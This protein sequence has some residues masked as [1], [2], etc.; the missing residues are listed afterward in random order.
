MTRT[1]VTPLSAIE[2]PRKV[3][4][5]EFLFPTSPNAS[6]STGQATSAVYHS[7]HVYMWV[8]ACVGVVT[9]MEKLVKL[10]V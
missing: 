9:R 8:G 1:V 2:T 6:T 5:T 10:T 4:T 7:T 3:S